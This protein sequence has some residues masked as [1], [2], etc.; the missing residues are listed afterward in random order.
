MKRDLG[1]Y[2]TGDGRTLAR[3]LAYRWNVLDPMGS[4]DIA[5]LERDTSGST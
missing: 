1:S 3:G 5:K 2:R 4:Q